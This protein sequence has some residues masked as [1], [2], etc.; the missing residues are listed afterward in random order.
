MFLMVKM[1]A[2][3]KSH[4]KILAFIDYR[5]VMFS[6]PYMIMHL[7]QACMSFKN[8]ILVLLL[9]TVI[10]FSYPII[11][12]IENHCTAEYRAKMAKMFV[13]IFG[14]KWCI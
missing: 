14:G 5:C 11:I 8:K 9:S 1:V 12:S 3:Q 4:I 2:S 7:L 6:K 13:E 10:L